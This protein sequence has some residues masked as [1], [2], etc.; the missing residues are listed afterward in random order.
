MRAIVDADRVREAPELAEFARRAAEAAAAHDAARRWPDVDAS[1][2]TPVPIAGSA[3]MA[4][5]DEVA[6]DGRG[7]WFDQGSNDFASMPVGRHVLAGV[8]F[9]IANP[10]TSGGRAA[11]VLFGTNRDFFPERAP[12][13]PV[14]RKARR[15]YFLHGY[16]W[17]ET[18]GAPV[19]AYRIRYADGATADFVC[20]AKAEIGPWHGSFVPSDAKLAVESSNPVLGTVN[21][22]CA[23]WE[24]PRP[25]VEILGIEPV[26]A[27]SAAV[28]AVVAITAER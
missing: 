17:D 19:L 1:R 5:A 13:I 4:F 11:I 25:D 9:E 28:P 26:S 23:R 6:G 12:E 14:G 24:N 21:V 20:R 18:P 10:A 15:L 3:N 22:Q 16:G 7:G 2:C 8:P 27:R